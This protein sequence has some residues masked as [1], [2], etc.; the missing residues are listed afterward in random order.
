M[1][2]KFPY[3]PEFQ[4]EESVDYEVLDFQFW[5]CSERKR[6]QL[7]RLYKH[8]SGRKNLANLE[9]IVTHFYARRCSQYNAL[10]TS[11]VAH[12]FI[13]NATYE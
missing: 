3:V 2:K 6:K 12:V 1:K 7:P 10:P 5:S 9:N 4:F 13:D 8:T 11:V